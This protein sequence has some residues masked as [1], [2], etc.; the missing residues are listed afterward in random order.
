M[1]EGIEAKGYPSLKEIKETC[2]YPSEERFKKG[3]V[4]VIECV[5][6]IPCNPCEVACK[7]N[8]ITVG[9]PMTNL[10]HLDEDLCTGCGLCVA[11]CPGQAIFIV[12]KTYSEIEAV[13]SFPYEYLP[14]PEKGQE[15]QTVNRAGENIC[16]GKVVR[17]N[18]SRKNDCTPVVTVSIP[19][20]YVDEVRSIKRQGR[21]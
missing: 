7:F 10:P 2:G 11:Q 19:K 12:D 6:E 15:V 1:C 21:G 17:V 20:K 8:A 4:A 3:P 18:N 9:E 16:K 14:L 13:V 5:Q